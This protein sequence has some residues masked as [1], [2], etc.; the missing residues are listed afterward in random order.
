[1]DGRVR[2]NA[3]LIA[4]VTIQAQAM[5]EPEA[6]YPRAGLEAADR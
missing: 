5:A 2:T 1:M 6:G 3:G 4:P